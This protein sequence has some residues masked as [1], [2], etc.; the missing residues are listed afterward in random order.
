MLNPRNVIAKI[1]K[2]I[3]RISRKLNFSSKILIEPIARII[4]LDAI[5]S[6]INVGPIKTWAK[7]Y[8]STILKYKIQFSMMDFLLN[9]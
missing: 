8:G 2:K 6:G 9:F 3:P 4:N 5:S 1:I 7:K